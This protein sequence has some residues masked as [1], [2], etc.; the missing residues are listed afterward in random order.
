MTPMIRHVAPDGTEIRDSGDRPVRG[1]SRGAPAIDVEGNARCVDCLNLLPAD[2]GRS[3]Y[4]DDCRDVARRRAWQKRNESRRSARERRTQ[5]QH[6]EHWEGRG[7]TYGRSGLYIDASLLR[8]LQD[9]VS[10]LLS[11]HATWAELASEPVD[12]MQA[13]RYREGLRDVLRAV[14]ETNETLRGPFWPRTDRTA[15]RRRPAP[16]QTD[17]GATGSAIRDA[18]SQNPLP[19]Q[20]TRRGS[21]PDPEGST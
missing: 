15:Q 1:G 11:T 8:D 3:P 16:A 19:P 6:E 20:G 17:V 18:T 12:P 13:A 2:R 21:N 7:Y 9:A 10:G 5:L 14:A 4:C